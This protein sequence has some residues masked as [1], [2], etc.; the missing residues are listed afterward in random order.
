MTE[1]VE[2]LVPVTADVRRDARRGLAMFLALIVAFSVVVNAWAFTHPA[3]AAVAIAVLMCTPALASVITRL[4]RREGFADVSFRFG[5]PRRTLPWFLAGALVPIAVGV[6]AYGPAWATGL[7]GFSGTVSGVALGVG[8]MFLVA[9]WG[10][11]VFAAG[12]EIGWRGYMLPRMIDA[13][14]PRPV[15]TSGLVWGAWHLPMVLGGFYASGSNRWLSAVLLL[16]SATAFSVFLARMRMESGSI[17]PV[18]FAHS[19]WNVVIQ[20]PFD[21]AVTGEG[22][23]LWVGEPG[24][25]TCLVLIVLAVVVSRGQWSDHRTP[26]GDTRARPAV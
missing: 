13:G 9:V 22:A 1:A 10:T 7:A 16:V 8:S 17:W 2:R 20:N 4:V 15:L 21:G 19:A 18:V 3:D 23:D 24:I 14:V 11:C 12:E 5:R 6:L 26:P 25:L